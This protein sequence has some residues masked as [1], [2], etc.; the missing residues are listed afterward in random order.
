MRPLPLKPPKVFPVG[1]DLPNPSNPP[2]VRVLR[3]PAE[4]WV[5]SLIAGQLSELC[6][7]SRFKDDPFGVSREDAAQV[8]NQIWL[9]YIGSSPMIGTVV[10]YMTAQPPEGVLPLDGGSYHKDEYPELYAMIDPALKDG[11]Y[12]ILPDSTGAFARGSEILSTFQGGEASVTLNES[13]MPSHSHSSVPHFHAYMG[14]VF[15]MG[16]IG[17]GVP[18]PNA[19][20]AP[21]VTEAATIG[22]NATGGGQPHNNIPPFFTVKYGIW[23]I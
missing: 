12:F 10:A 13:Q 18:V 23:Y 7:P 9:D 11:D 20:S 3:I 1:E 2:I 17:V 16:E 21:L 8:F 14:A 6:Y 5:Q 15:S 19:V 22:I 4:R